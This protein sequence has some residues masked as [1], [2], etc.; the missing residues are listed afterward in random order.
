MET[1]KT[2]DGC[3]NLE[4]KRAGEAGSLTSDYKNY[5][6]QNRVVLAKNGHLD[7]GN[8]NETI[9]I[10]LCTYSQ[11]IY[12]KG[13]TNGEKTISLISGAGKTGQLH[14]KE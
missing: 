11:I 1:Q 3:G 14:V 4:K 9:E 6:Y 7:H 13:S 2:S 10:N 12:D 5:S 8:R